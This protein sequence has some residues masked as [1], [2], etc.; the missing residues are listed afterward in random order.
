VSLLQGLARTKDK[1][2]AVTLFHELEPSLD[3]HPLS[4]WL[5]L[6]SMAAMDGQFNSRA[7]D[8]L[9]DLERVWG[10]GDFQSYL[11]RPDVKSLARPLLQGSPAQ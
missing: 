3:G 5:V 6:G 10:S 2:R 9:K 7:R 11:A 1:V 8:A 4:R